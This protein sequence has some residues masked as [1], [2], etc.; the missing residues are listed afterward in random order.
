M[1]QSGY[2]FPVAVLYQSAE[3]LAVPLV[4]IFGFQGPAVDE[5]S[6]SWPYFSRSNAGEADQE[7]M[8][9]AR[10]ALWRRRSS[11]LQWQTAG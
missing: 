10:W 4:L 11:A 5:N 7:L 1:L 2:C 9:G 6:T 3:L 8:Q